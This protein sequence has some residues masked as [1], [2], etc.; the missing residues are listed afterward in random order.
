MGYIPGSGGDDEGGCGAN[1]G[2][3]GAGTG[4]GTREFFR[5]DV[6]WTS[7]ALWIVLCWKYP[8]Q[9]DVGIE[10]ESADTLSRAAVA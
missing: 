10:K 1:T 8:G 4:T 2:G 6:R 7:G 9:S 5:R 3:A